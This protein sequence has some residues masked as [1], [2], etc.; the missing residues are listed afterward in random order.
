[1]RVVVI[2]GGFGGLAAAARLAKIGHEVTLLERSDRLG[3]ALGT[4]Q[5]D[6]FVFDTGPTY[7]LLPAVTRDLFRKT[8]RPLEREAE[9]V[10][11]S[12]IR[13]HHFAD[14]SQLALTGGSRAAQMNAFDA[15]AP[16]LGDE[17]AGWVDGLGAVWERLRRDYLERPWD[18][19]L[20]HPD[21]RKLLDS[22]TSLA[23]RFA[24]VFSDPRLATVAGHPY[25]AFGHDLRKVPVWL[26]TTSYV[27]Q[28]FGA[29]TVPGGMGTLADALTKRLA[30]RKVDV[31]LSTPVADLVVAGDRVTGV[32]TADGEVS[33]DAVVCGVAPYRL[34]ALRRLTRKL[35]STTP[36]A[37]THLGLAGNAW[38]DGEDRQ[39]P[40]E[41][42]LHGR[43]AESTIV[44]RSGGTA[45][46]G[47]R[48][49]TVQHHGNLG[50]DVLDAL[51]ARGVDLRERI[52][53]RLDRTPGE[54]VEQWGGSPA[55]TQWA[56]RSTVRNRLG[57]RTPLDGL[58][59]VGA[60]ATPGAS[61]P[62][63][64]LSAALVAQTIGPA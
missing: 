40:G 19:G 43:G 4:V 26:G 29:W 33:A 44:L 52:V 12:V 57:P 49:V 50:G 35:R 59:A 24:K 48:V 27:E 20:A 7:T 51:A 36:P 25:A 39:A 17:W 30:T 28:K 37:L 53:T 58:Y 8:G 56:G 34:P 22:R 11:V 61:L 62:F 60:H 47:H 55:G 46:V 63:T 42:V 10:P 5:V 54:L 3:G 31:H 1:M 21:S 38:V 23:A 9:L 15:L 14:G 64:G 6:D 45:P 18:R 2:G 13:E 41:V 32:R 16:G